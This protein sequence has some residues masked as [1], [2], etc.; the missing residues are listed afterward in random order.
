MKEIL[1]QIHIWT[2]GIAM[3]SLFLASYVVGACSLAISIGSKFVPY[4]THVAMVITIVIFLTS[5]GTL[6]FIMN[7]LMERTERNKS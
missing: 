3:F 1:H 6:A 7:D 2:V 5:I 4:N